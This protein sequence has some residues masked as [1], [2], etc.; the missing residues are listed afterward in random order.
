MDPISHQPTLALG[1][2]FGT[3]SVRAV[4]LDLRSGQLLAEESASYDHGVIDRELPTGG[5]R[6]PAHYA[7]QHPADWMKSL[8]KAARR[9]LRTAQAHG[10]QVAGIGVDFTSCTMLPCL[11]DGTPLCMVHP[12]DQQP[13]AW[14]KLWKHHGA[15]PA[16]D[17]MNEVARQ[18]KERFLKHYGG[19]IGIEWFF[20]KMLETLTNAPR[21]YEQAGLFVE[22]GDWLVWQLTSGPWPDCR[23]D[24]L[25]L[26]TCQAGYKALWSR[27]D[28]YPSADYLRAVHPRFGDVVARKMGSK[29]LAPGQLAGALSPAAAKLLGLSPGTAVSAAII[30]A[31]AGVPGAGVAGADALVMVIG[32]SA[33]HMLNSW[34]MKEAAGIAGVVEDGILPGYVGYE[35]G[36]ASV[37]DAFA[38]VARALGRDHAELTRLAEAQLPG[39]GGVRALDWLNGCRTPLMD[40]RLTGAYA[41]LTLASGPGQLYRAMME[42]TAYGLRWIRDTLTDAGIPIKSYV[43]S[44]GLPARSPLLMQI[45]ADVLNRPIR[46]AAQANSVAVGAAILGAAASGRVSLAQ[47]IRRMAPLPKAAAYRPNATSA[48]AYD[49]LYRDYLAMAAAARQALPAAGM[50]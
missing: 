42:A 36:Q 5:G 27:R 23:F 21:V 29:L 49:A 2:D 20:P 7:L 11:R 45:Y 10:E 12:L 40:A 3:E 30:D 14:P 44:G 18:R 32:T 22:A 47:A 8:A 6:L 33:C 31:H 28:G 13:L 26:S 35:T 48:R 37:G 38:W 41:G 19:A 1:C 4:L 43:A 15:Q 39:S 17:R 24:D 34:V 9:A 46:V 25:V 16:T 50:R